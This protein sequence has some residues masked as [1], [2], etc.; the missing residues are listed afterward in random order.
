M[1][2]LAKT[3]TLAFA[4]LCG[5]GRVAYLNRGSIPPDKFREN[6]GW[7]DPCMAKQ[8]R[9]MPVTDEKQDGIMRLHIPLQNLT[10]S[11]ISCE[12]VVRF[13]DK[14]GVALDDAWGWRPITVDAQ[15]TDYI[16]VSAPDGRAAGYKIVVR[17]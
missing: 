5:C 1:H 9:I 14:E 15:E 12:V 11:N 17:R 16:D 6:R 2:R 4:C 8:I 3:A 10:L 13:Y 7:V